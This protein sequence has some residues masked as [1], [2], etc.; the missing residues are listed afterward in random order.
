MTI[1]SAEIN[2]NFQFIDNKIKQINEFISNK[3]DLD[4]SSKTLTLIEIWI[5]Q[6]QPEIMQA[7][8]AHLVSIINC[9]CFYFKNGQNSQ[10]KYLIEYYLDLI[11]N[12]FNF[13]SPE[14]ILIIT[15]FLN[16]YIANDESDFN[17]LQ[18]ELA[19]I[20]PTSIQEESLLEKLV[21][22]KSKVNVYFAK[23]KQGLNISS[24]SEFEN[25]SFAELSPEPQLTSELKS[26]PEIVKKKKIIPSVIYFD[27]EGK[28]HR[29]KRLPKIKKKPRDFFESDNLNL[30]EFI[31]KRQMYEANLEEIMLSVG[32]EC[33]RL[34]EIE[35][36]N[37][38]ET[39]NK[40]VKAE[41]SLE[42]K[43]AELF[44][45]LNRIEKTRAEKTRARI[46]RS[47]EVKRF[48]TAKVW[49]PIL[50]SIQERISLFK[51]QQFVLG[52]DIL[53]TILTDLLSL[54]GN[55]NKQIVKEFLSFINYDNL[56]LLV[57]IDKETYDLVE[58][59]NL[60][61]IKID[62]VRENLG[63][64]KKYINYFQQELGE[65][66]RTFSNDFILY[67]FENSFRLYKLVKLNSNEFICWPNYKFNNIS[68]EIKLKSP[69]FLA[70]V[71]SLDEIITNQQQAINKFLKINYKN[72]NLYQ[73]NKRS[74]SLYNSKKNIFTELFKIIKHFLINIF[75]VRFYFI[76]EN[77]FLRFMQKL[78]EFIEQNQANLTID[79]VSNF[80]K[81]LNWKLLVSC[82][83]NPIHLYKKD[84]KERLVQFLFLAII[85][86]KFQNLTDQLPSNKKY[87]KNTRN[88]VKHDIADKLFNLINE[89]NRNNVFYYRDCN[90]TNL[91]EK[92]ESRKKVVAELERDEE[93]NDLF[94]KIPMLKSRIRLCQQELTKLFIFA[95]SAKES[96]TQ[97][98]D[99]DNNFE[100]LTPLK[101][102]FFKQSAKV[103]EEENLFNLGLNRH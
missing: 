75:I 56:K 58:N 51:G 55:K 45:R 65:F 79:S 87:I 49:G 100:G 5:K 21:L 31:D 50:A 24:S 77:Y 70:T 47:K 101:S 22:F 102:S 7:N 68:E 62:K 46:L 20:L 83:I 6:V 60:I 16:K 92:A 73:Q 103:I 88:N 34:A 43:D 57:K 25:I 67:F 71:Y 72:N 94:K 17:K 64:P 69:A 42:D 74:P 28:G 59:L 14:K 93:I 35:I 39:S 10:N 89:L 82:G 66:A 48:K 4:F 90:Q 78:N 27:K 11:L 99:N 97:L 1:V 33:K 40:N 36:P 86:Q 12:N 19:M 81:I 29:V 44:R 9:I 96:L 2:Y 80:I 8:S 32:K 18:S 26:P 95:N 61:L 52:Q 13:F 53:D 85:N 84:T 91:I 54:K 30:D 63:Y 23:L 76:D 98:K 15:S 38:A 37:E 3:K 41:L